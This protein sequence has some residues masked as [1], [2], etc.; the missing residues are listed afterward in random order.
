[1]IIAL[2][3][4]IGSNPDKQNIYNQIENAMVEYCLCF[5]FFGK[6]ILF[7]LMAWTPIN[8]GHI[9][10]WGHG[11]EKQKLENL[12]YD[13]EISRDESNLKRSGAWI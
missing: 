5:F 7:E 12:H 11:D 10:K 1:M 13:Q 3:Y 9:E 4:H 6:K 2:V 8:Y